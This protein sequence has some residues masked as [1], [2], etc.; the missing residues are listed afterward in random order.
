MKQVK[1]YQE[2][3]ILR[4]IGKNG[5]LVFSEDYQIAWVRFNKDLKE[6]FTYLNPQKALDDIRGK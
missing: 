6:E 4:A 3:K 5:I 1:Q 2:K